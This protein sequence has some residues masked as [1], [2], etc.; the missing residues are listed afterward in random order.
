VRAKSLTA[1]LLAGMPASAGAR[2][3]TRAALE[4]GAPFSRRFDP[5][6][7]LA[8]HSACLMQLE[9]PGGWVGGVFALVANKPETRPQQGGNAVDLSVVLP[10][11]DGGL[12]DE[13]LTVTCRWRWAPWR[14]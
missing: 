4:T 12:V 11:S 13:G 9:L 1:L 6:A 5:S 7:L 2:L 14:R 3:G 8:L 10:Q